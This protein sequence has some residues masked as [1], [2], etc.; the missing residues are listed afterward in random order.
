L[1]GKR[2]KLITRDTDYA[3]RACLYIACCKHEMVT[4]SELV[5]K[6]HMPRPF[7]RKILQ[8][9]QKRGILKSTKGRGG[10]FSLRLSPRRIFL[11]DL[12]RIFQ[13]EFKMIECTF[14]KGLCPE[15]RTCLFMGKLKNIEH[16]VSKQLEA[17][18]VSSLIGKTQ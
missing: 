6:L 14:K 10:G 5:E 8:T 3:L 2:M 11:S 9:L 13:G 12:I 17:I 7:L 15:M 4:V 18:T 16:Y 1:E